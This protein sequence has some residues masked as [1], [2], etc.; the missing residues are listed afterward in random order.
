MTVNNSSGN[1]TISGTGSIAGATTTLTKLGSGVLTLSNTGINTYGGGTTVSAGTLLIGA[2]G[3]LPAASN[4]TIT[5]GT[6]QLGA[7]TGGETLSSLSITG[8][9]A[10]DVNNNHIIISYTGSQATG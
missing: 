6:L 4:V 8:G 2:A 9:G 7:S 10:F 3:A 1:Y 5:G